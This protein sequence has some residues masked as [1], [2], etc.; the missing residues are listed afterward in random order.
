MALLRIE[1]K[2]GIA[3]VSLN[4]PDKRNAMSFDLLRE[5]VKTAEK[6]KKTA[7]FVVSS[8]LVKRKSLV[9]ALILPI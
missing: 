2:N 8:S 6:L 5:L 9:Q 4:R 3:T 7:A 1:N